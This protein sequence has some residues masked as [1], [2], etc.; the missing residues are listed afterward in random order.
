MC[1]TKFSTKFG[2][3]SENFSFW[4]VGSRGVPSLGPPKIASQGRRGFLKEL[5]VCDD[6]GSPCTTGGA[7]SAV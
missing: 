6:I 7:L 5:D 1:A 2:H 4:A 3:V